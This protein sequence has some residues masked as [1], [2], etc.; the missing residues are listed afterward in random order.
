[1][2]RKLLFKIFPP[3]IIRVPT[4]LKFLTYSI[5][6]KKYLKIFDLENGADICFEVEAINYKN[7]NLRDSFHPEKMFQPLL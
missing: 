3:K 2:I 7:S 5:Y 4:G 1:M 6:G